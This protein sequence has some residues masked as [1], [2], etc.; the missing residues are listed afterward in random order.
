[1]FQASPIRNTKAGT[2]FYE[3]MGEIEQ[4]YNDM[5]LS[6][7][8]EDWDRYEEIYEEKKDLLKWR[9][10]IKKKQRIFNELNKR[11]RVIRFDRSMSADNK[12][13]R[14]DQL[15]ALRNQIMDKIAGSPALR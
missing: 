3:R 13:V 1:M 11:I 5:Q 15:Y 9:D 4:A 7:K 14:I 2:A 10:F 6:K 12:R 8:L